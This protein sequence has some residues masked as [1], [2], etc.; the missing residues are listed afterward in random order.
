MLRLLTIGFLLFGSIPAFA[1]QFITYACDTC[2]YQQAGAVAALKAPAQ[3]C[4]W[5]NPPGS[6]PTPDDVECYAPAATLIVANPLTQQAFKFRVQRQCTSNWCEHIPL[7]T[8]LTLNADEQELMQ[9]FYTLHNTIINAIN[10]AQAASPSGAI[11]VSVANLSQQLGASSSQSGDAEDCSKSLLHY[12][13]NPAETQ[14]INEQM[15]NAIKQHV[16]DSTWR[17]YVS[18]TMQTGGAKET[19]ISL[20]ASRSTKIDYKHVSQEQ[21]HIIHTGD[22]WEN[23]LSFKVEYIGDINTRG[24]KKIYLKFHL[25]REGS[26]VHGRNLGLLTGQ[27][28]SYNFINSP[29]NVSSCILDFVSTGEHITDLG[30]TGAPINVDQGGG[31]IEQL[32]PKKTETTVCSTTKEG[33]TCTVTRFQFLGPCA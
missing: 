25:D 31:L 2:D 22:S 1:Y 33:T 17:N 12:V 15:A 28:G 20:N 30:V 16:A 5:T 14:L 11:S 7:I 32:C 24:I 27:G 9:G 3:E 8:D 10:A 26:V 19:I 18:T 21:Y 4:L 29:N 6:T 23:R 13:S